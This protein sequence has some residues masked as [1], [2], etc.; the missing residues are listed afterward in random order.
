MD[1]EIKDLMHNQTLNDMSADG[2]KAYLKL[3]EM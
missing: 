1:K 2:S 3:Q